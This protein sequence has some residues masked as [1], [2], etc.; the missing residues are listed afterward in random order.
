MFVE[1]STD[2][3]LCFAIDT[4]GQVEVTFSI[5]LEATGGSAGTIDTL[6]SYI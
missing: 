3:Q 6:V 2:N 1:G 4:Q 5:D